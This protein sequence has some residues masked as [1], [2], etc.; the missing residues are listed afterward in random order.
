MA[1]FYN[2]TDVSGVLINVS[3]IGDHLY[4]LY[5]LP[6]TEEWDNLFYPTLRFPHPTY[7]HPQQHKNI[8]QLS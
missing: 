2:A 8:K 4:N 6:V 7:L 1:I 5:F 3:H